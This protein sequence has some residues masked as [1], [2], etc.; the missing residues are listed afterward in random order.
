MILG[1]WTVDIKER[2]KKLTDDL[3]NVELHRIVIRGNTYRRQRPEN[4]RFR[5]GSILSSLDTSKR[6]IKSGGVNWLGVTWR[7]LY[8]NGQLP[9]LN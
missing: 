5:E 4:S 6:G 1:I 8:N 3:K 2:L 7:K 9:T